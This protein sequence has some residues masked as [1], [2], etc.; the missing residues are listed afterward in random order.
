[1]GERKNQVF[2]FYICIY[3][4]CKT[5]AHVRCNIDAYIGCPCTHAYIIC[6][7]VAS[8]NN[9]DCTIVLGTAPLYVATVQKHKWAYMM[10]MHVYIYVG[11]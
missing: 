8:G 10:Y 3:I 7:A 5:H 1:M 4:K 9:G 6:F 2:V 11:L